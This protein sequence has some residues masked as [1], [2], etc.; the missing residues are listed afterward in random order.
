MDKYYSGK[1]IG[2]ADF[3][4]PFPQQ[5]EYSSPAR[6]VWNIVHTG[7]LIPE[8]HEIFVCAKGCLRGVVLTAAEMGQMGRYSALEIQEK[9]VITGHIEEFMI[10]GVGDILSKLSYR[11][12]AVLLYINCQHFFLAYDQQY[13]FRTLRETYPDID[14]AD[15]YMIP[16]L[17]KSGMSPDRKMRIQLYSLLKQRPEN[18]RQINLMGSNHAIER[19]SE[20]YEMLENKKYSIR[21]LN[22]CSTYEEYQQLAA[23]RLNIIYEPQ[24]INAAKD[25]KERLGIPYLYLPCVFSEHEI[26]LR[27][28]YLLAELYEDHD[29]DWLAGKEREASRAIKKARE[30]IGDTAIAIDYT[31]VFRVLSLSRRLLE[32]GF[33]LKRIYVDVMNPEERRDFDWIKENHPEIEIF[34][35]SR[36]DMRRMKGR[37]SEKSGG[38]VLALGQKAAYFE[39]TEHFTDITEGGGLFGYDGIIRMAELMTDAF[40]NKKDVRELVQKKGTGCRCILG[41]DPDEYARIPSELSRI[42]STGMKESASLIPT[43]SSDEF[44][45]CS[46]LYDLGGMTVMHDASGCNST[47]TTH[48]EPRW[49]DSDSLVY[50]SA[51]SER[52]SLLGDDGKLMRD[53]SDAA[54]MLDPEFIALVGAPIPYMTGTDLKGIARVIEAERGTVCMG[55]QTNGMRD[56]VR[57]ISLALEAIADRYCPK[58]D[59]EEPRERTKE[60][61]GYRAGARMITASDLEGAENINIIGVTPMDFHDMDAVERIR[62]WIAEKNVQKVPGTI[63]SFGMNGDLAG[64]SNAGSADLNLVLSSGGLKCAELLRE[65]FGTPFVVGVPCEAFRMMRR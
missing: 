19:T 36:P 58:G 1:K 38:K 31:L 56:Y 63:L 18:D 4:I 34:P 7:M 35:T 23:G 25:M 61:A 16:T 41:E 3:P 2:E 27:Y 14:F 30:I 29:D 65:R 39:Q 17:R 55:F 5:L 40:L 60:S 20:L 54:D 13:V 26:S 50:I 37:L 6:G 47:Y 15:C 8:C 9:Y 53:I 59:E 44:G 28:K 46:A 49:Y 21:S 32:A 51:V 42:S 24:A 12:K 11:P 52:E 62:S 45:V 64:Y 48:D 57:G 10:K 22:D 43:Y 33:N